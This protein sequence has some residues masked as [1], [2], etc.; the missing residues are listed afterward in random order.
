MQ[1]KPDDCGLGRCYQQALL[2]VVH[3]T[4]TLMKMLD[5]NL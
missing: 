2:P 1:F 3:K 5:F 4:S